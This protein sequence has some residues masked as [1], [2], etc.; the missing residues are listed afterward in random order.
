[1]AVVSVNPTQVQKKPDAIERIVQGLAIAKNAFGIVSDYQNIKKTSAEN[2]VIDRQ[3]KGIYTPGELSKDY[4]EQA[5]PG[6][7]PDGQ[8]PEAPRYSKLIPSKIQVML[9]DG[10]VTTKDFV[11][12]DDIEKQVTQEKDLRNQFEG[13]QAVQRTAQVAEAYKK[14]QSASQD[15]S[16]AGNIALVYGFMKLNDPTSSVREGEYATAK[17]AGSLPTWLINTYNSALKGQFLTPQQRSN[18]L[19]TSEKIMKSQLEGIAPILD[20]YNSL[21]EQGGFQKKNVTTDY[22][23]MLKKPDPVTV[24]DKYNQYLKKNGGK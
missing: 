3:S 24:D 14:I 9:P 5:A 8:T 7:L 18:F 22:S 12:K 11:R 17:N 23:G 20:K 13:D 2:A 1:M 6:M 16:P 10:T 15:G 19:G 21:A 4:A